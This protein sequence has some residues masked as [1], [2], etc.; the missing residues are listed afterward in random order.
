MTTETDNFVRTTIHIMIDDNGP[1][2]VALSSGAGWID[3]PVND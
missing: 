1:Y 3:A 2:L